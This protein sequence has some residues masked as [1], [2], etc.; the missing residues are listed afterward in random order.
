MPKPIIYSKSESGMALIYTLFAV[1][2]MSLISVALLKTQGEAARSYN[3]II[4]EELSSD[5]NDY[6]VQAA[7][8]FLK[9]SSMNGTL[10]N[11]TTTG[12]P[13]SLTSLIAQVN[14][15]YSNTYTRPSFSRISNQ[16]LA[17]SNIS[18]SIRYIKDGVSSSGGSSG[19]VSKSRT[20]GAMSSSTIKFYRLTTIRDDA[21]ERVEYEIILSI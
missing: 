10:G 3:V 12:T 20:Y 17:Y 4:N 7:F 18:C 21:S 1:L 11:I 2:M 15:A 16:S 13:I 5:S 9:T 8:D 14:Y 6:C 19:T